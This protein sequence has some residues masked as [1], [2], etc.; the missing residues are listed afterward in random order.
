MPAIAL[1]PIVAP[2]P[3]AVT[4]T[5]LVLRDGSRI[6]VDGPIREE[7]GRV[8]FKTS[9]RLFSI[10]L[11]EVDL[12]ATRR[13]VRGLAVT[14]RAAGPAKL[15]VGDAERAKLLHDLEQNHTGTPAPASQ[16]TAVPEPAPAQVASEA[17][18]KGEALQ[19]E[20]SWRRQA[21]AKEDAVRQAN[22]ELTLL[23]DRAESLRSQIRSFV[24]LG[25]STGQFTYQTTELAYTEE[26]IPHAALE[27]ER[28]SR[29]LDQFRD[30][31]RR[32]GVMPGWI[33]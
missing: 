10:A 2:S 6:D 9:T 5:T 8:L 19:D 7:G 23:R 29:A 17:A 24:G 20:W 28:A 26:Q 1:P 30:D 13:A 14:D 25:Y 22:E 16:L 18:K 15:R 21:R 33:R 3:P 4:G 11:D 31:A 32:L 12:A 27:V